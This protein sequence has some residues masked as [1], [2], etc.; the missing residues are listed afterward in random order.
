MTVEKKLGGTL[1]LLLMQA[2]G[3]LALILMEVIRGVEK[4]ANDLS[5]PPVS[6]LVGLLC[7]SALPIIA[8]STSRAAWARWSAMAVAVLLALFHALHILEHAMASDSE[9]TMLI[10]FTMFLPCLLSVILLWQARRAESA[11]T[12]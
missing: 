9:L 10:I 2:G 11:Q 7:V 4:G 8:L 5:V 1:A 6:M 3:V 12:P